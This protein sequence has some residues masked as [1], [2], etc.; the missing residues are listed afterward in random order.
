MVWVELVEEMSGEGGVERR[1]LGLH[2]GEAFGEIS[3]ELLAVDLDWMYGCVIHNVSVRDTDEMCM[4][5]MVVTY[6]P[7][8]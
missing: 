2:D 1:G 7:F 3:G 4:N 5:F 6:H 8:Y